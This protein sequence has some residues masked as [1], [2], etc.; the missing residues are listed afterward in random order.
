MQSIVLLGDVP[1]CQ[2]LSDDASDG[3]KDLM[4]LV[5]EAEGT[6]NIACMKASHT[7]SRDEYTFHATVGPTEE[8]EELHMVR[9]RTV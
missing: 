7:T 6:D 1:A 3:A 2:K 4:K 5:A 9:K 8:I